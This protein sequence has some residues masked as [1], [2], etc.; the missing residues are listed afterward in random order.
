[1]K[2]TI[3]AFV[4]AASAISLHAEPDPQVQNTAAAI[5]AAGVI[6]QA[7]GTTGGH[8]SKTLQSKTPSQTSSQTFTGRDANGPAYT[9]KYHG[10]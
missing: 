3:L 8:D 10:F 5:T 6:T 2:F 9:D 4:G 1:M 7:V